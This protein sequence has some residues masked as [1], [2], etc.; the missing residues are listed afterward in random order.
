M[1]FST[2]YDHPN[3]YSLLLYSFH[4]LIFHLLILFHLSTLTITLIV[5]NTLQIHLHQHPANIGTLFYMTFFYDCIYFLSRCL[6]SD[7]YSFLYVK[8]KI[9]QK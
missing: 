2:S 1:G 6:L 7:T 4:D 3:S 8:I 5:I 9:E